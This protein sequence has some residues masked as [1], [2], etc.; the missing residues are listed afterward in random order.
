MLFRSTIT[1]VVLLTGSSPSVSSDI[2]EREE[3]RHL[4]ETG[5]YQE[6]TDW[7]D[8][9]AGVFPLLEAR[10]FRE[11]GKPDQALK[12]L[13]THPRFKNDDPDLLASAAEL[14]RNRGNDD[15]AERHLKK[16]LT[17]SSEHI[18]AN[19][20]L[21]LVK[22]DQGKR[23][24]G[25][26]RLRIAIDIYKAMSGEDAQGLTPEQFVWFGKA[27]EG[28][29]K[30][31]DAYEVMYDSALYINKTS[32]AAHVASG[33]A[34]H[35][36]YNYPDSRSHFRD[37]IETN[38][39]SVEALV[40]LARSTW[41]D[42]RFPG[43]RGKEVAE[44]I[45]RACAVSKQYPELLVLQGDIEFAAEHWQQAESHYREVLEVDPGHQ[46]AQGLLAS[47]MWS[48]ARIEEF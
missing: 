39:R 22:I 1:L 32:V 18:K 13:L 28:L 42:F 47:V 5:Q 4:I 38:P 26:K 16:A 29:N 43:D 41:S 30:F 10:L 14:E 35:S 8:E 23:S 44:L 15:A 17:V 19:C 11:T 31:R 33:K 7:V 6:A 3:L 40:G 37:A 45:D 2:D 27:C 20:M 46:V 24:E 34:L 25:E 21:G 12:S 36:K 9:E 48:T